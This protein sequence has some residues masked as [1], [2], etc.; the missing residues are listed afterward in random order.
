M[1]NFR[2]S[3]QLAAHEA[4]VRVL[5]SSLPP[6]ADMVHPT[7]VTDISSPSPLAHTTE[8]DGNGN[9]ILLHEYTLGPAETR[10]T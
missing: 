9:K 7:V 5:V 2:L 8:K 3:A 10:P 6:T 4:D 1:S